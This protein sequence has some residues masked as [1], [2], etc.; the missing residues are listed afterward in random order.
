MSDHILGFLL[1][2]PS[3]FPTNDQDDDMDYAQRLA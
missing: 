3:I 2:Q 1:L